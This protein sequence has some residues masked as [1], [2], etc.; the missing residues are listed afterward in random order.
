MKSLTALSV[1]FLLLSGDSP[2]LY[3]QNGSSGYERV[4]VFGEQH[5]SSQSRKPGET[6][7]PVMPS[8]DVKF[9]PTAL[10][11]GEVPIYCEH[12][13]SNRYSIEAALGITFEDYFRENIL[14]GKPLFPKPANEDRLSGITSRLGLRYFF[15]KRAP[16]GMYLSPELEYKNYR[17]DVHG[18]YL[19]SDGRYTSGK[20]RD[21]QSYSELKVLLGF[22]NTENY[23]HDFLFDW[24][25]GFGL[26]AGA[27]D[28]VSIDELNAGVIKNRHVNVLAPVL[29]FGLKLGLGL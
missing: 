19:D 8:W 16:S 25:V 9:C 11:R 26:R 20:L 22:Q 2:S 18:V 29:S 24:F 23:E 13:L 14:E 7:E 28:N 27:E 10:V 3:S 12:R 6:I 21:Q 5:I 17:K 15:R 4:N 1:V